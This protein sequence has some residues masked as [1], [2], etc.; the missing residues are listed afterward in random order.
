MMS[1]KILQ[2]IL[3]QNKLAIIKNSFYES[4]KYCSKYVSNDEEKVKYYKR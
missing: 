2:K 3:S 4:I 1:L